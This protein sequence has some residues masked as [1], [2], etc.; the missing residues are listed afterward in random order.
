MEGT[1]EELRRISNCPE[2]ATFSQLSH[3]HREVNRHD[4]TV[5]VMIVFVPCWLVSIGIKPFSHRVHRGRKLIGAYP[6][7]DAAHFPQPYPSPVLKHTS[8]S[9]KI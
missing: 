6:D 1:L 5:S 3:F 2:G 7:R 8:F 4:D 9:S